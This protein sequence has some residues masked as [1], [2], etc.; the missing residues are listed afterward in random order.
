[1]RKSEITVLSI[2]L[3]SFIIGI[4]LYSKMPERMAS[5]WNIQGEVDGYITK[6]WGLFLIPFVS[7]VLYLFFVLIPRIDPLKNN[8]E[9][10]RKYFDTFIVLLMSFLLYLYLLTIFWN[11]GFRFNFIQF[12]VPAFS[13][14]FFYTGVL[15]ENSKRNWF[16]GIRT[17]WTLSSDAVWS[18][19]HELGGK[20]FKIAALISLIGIV[21][22]NYAI[23]LIIL[24][25]FFVAIYT[26][27][28]SYFEYKKQIRKRIK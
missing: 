21:F 8:I 12:L 23:Y 4:Y 6:F 14:L 2:I 7:F 19:T 22:E 15:I 9:K 24:P 5:H 18:K 13:I 11:L 17:P 28:Y 10:F 27:V 16:V 1:M 20:L 25:I 3:I 26:T